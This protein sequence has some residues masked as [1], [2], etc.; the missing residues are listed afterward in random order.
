MFMFHQPNHPKPL[1]Q[2]AIV[3][4]IAQPRFRLLGVMEAI[5]ILTQLSIIT[6]STREIME[7]HTIVIVAS[8]LMEAPSELKRLDTVVSQLLH[9]IVPLTVPTVLAN[10]AE[11][12][13]N[14]EHAM[15]MQG[16]QDEMT[17]IQHRAHVLQPQHILHG[18][19][20]KISNSGETYIGQ[21]QT[22]HLEHIHKLGHVK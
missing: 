17:V 13:R 18:V 5:I 8:K 20:V 9:L 2:L 1:L 12:K 7:V 15:I 4:N 16:M 10:L 22:A 21:I 14:V 19:P 11:Q 6:N 3:E